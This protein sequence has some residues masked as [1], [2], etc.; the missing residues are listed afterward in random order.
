[1]IPVDKFGNSLSRNTFQIITRTGARLSETGYIESSRKPNLFYFIDTDSGITFFADFRGTEEV[2]IWED[3][4][5]L[6][7]WCL[8]E[9]KKMTSA[10]VRAIV[11]HFG[12]LGTHGITGR[13]S[14]YEETEPGGTI[15]DNDE[16]MTEYLHSEFNIPEFMLEQKVLTFYDQNGN[17]RFCGKIIQTPGF[18]C[19]EECRTRYIKKNIAMTLNENFREFC[20]N[21]GTRILPREIYEEFAAYLDI[22]AKP[23]SIIHHTSYFPEKTMVICED[24]HYKIHKTNEYPELKP[25]KGESGRFYRRHKIPQNKFN[26]RRNGQRISS[27][28]ALFFYPLFNDPNE[29]YRQISYGDSVEK[30]TQR[31]YELIIG[32]KYRTEPSS[33]PERTNIIICKDCGHKFNGKYRTTCPKCR[34]FFR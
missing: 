27:G 2:K 9:H 18:F 10:D 22:E 21:C 25:E 4:R 20:K 15:F 33:A 6:I 34:T 1:M 13:L 29:I 11:R 8:N 19:S 26:S 17:C 32:R 31:E 7:Y 5:P 14:F 16:L 12:N 30:V 3:T 23:K 24:C 28:R